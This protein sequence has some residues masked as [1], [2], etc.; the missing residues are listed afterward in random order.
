MQI[1]NKDDFWKTIIGDSTD[2][3]E[4][5]YKVLS[6]RGFFLELKDGI[7]N[8]LDNNHIEDFDYLDKLLKESGIGHLKIL[9]E[10]RKNVNV[11]DKWDGHLRKETHIVKDG[12]IELD[13]LSRTTDLI[14]LITNTIVTDQIGYV[15]CWT[16]GTN[17]WWRFLNRVNGEKVPVK[18]LETYIARF[19]RALTACGMGTAV[20]CDGNHRKL[21][22][23]VWIGFEWKGNDMF[24][25]AICEKV[26]NERFNVHFSLEIPLYKENQ[27]GLYYKLNKAADY[28]FENRE[29]FRNL[30]KEFYKRYTDNYLS[31]NTNDER[32]V[33]DFDKY[34]NEEVK[35]EVK[36]A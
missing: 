14:A 24:Y 25:K 9:H 20:S 8:V 13:D 6:A 18:E 30:K 26:L 31:K 5:L 15:C 10:R 11:S 12:V 19:I 22:R 34:L 27:Y 32:L 21:A 28:L 2:N 35:W 1:K 16:G 36:C 33:I 17:P 23:K 4:K 7:I 29:Y 3:V